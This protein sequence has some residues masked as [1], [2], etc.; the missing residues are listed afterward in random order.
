MEDIMKRRYAA[1]F[2]AGALGVTMSLPAQAAPPP[3]APAHGYR[4]KQEREYR[5]VYYPA[6]QVY[7]AP[8]EHVWFWMNGG[9]WQF[10]VNLPTQYRIQS[11][12]G[13]PVVLGSARPY[14]EHVYVEENYGRPWREK[15]EHKKEKHKEK[16]KHKEKHNKHH[17]HD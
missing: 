13:V 16:D 6:Q 8:E 15:H 11:T 14:V 9:N 5:Y 1:L 10:G 12:S 7:Y 3:W 4:A 2:A 17:G